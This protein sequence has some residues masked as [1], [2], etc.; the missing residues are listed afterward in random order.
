MFFHST[1]NEVHRSPFLF[2]V[3]HYTL[4]GEGV[5]FLAIFSLDLTSHIVTLVTF[6]PS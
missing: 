1:L 6:L 4:K 3:D 5:L 2:I